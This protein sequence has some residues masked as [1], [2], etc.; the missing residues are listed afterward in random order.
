MK[1]YI[2]SEKR[3]LELLT[4]EANLEALCAGGVDDWAWYYKSLI[5]YLDCDDEV[6][7]LDQAYDSY[8]YDKMLKEFG[9]AEIK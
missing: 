1:K 2:I 5:N 6:E 3:L 7:D 4:R 8:V 9:D